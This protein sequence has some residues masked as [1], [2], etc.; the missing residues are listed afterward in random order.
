MIVTNCRDASCSVVRFSGCGREDCLRSLDH[1]ADWL[2]L[3]LQPLPMSR[4]PSSVSQL[5]PEVQSHQSQELSEP[6]MPRPLGDVR[7]GA[8]D[9]V[10]WLFSRRGQPPTGFH[11]RA[12]KRL[13]HTLSNRCQSF[14]TTFRNSRSDATGVKERG[15]RQASAPHSSKKL[16]VAKRC[17]LR[18]APW[19][20]PPINA[21]VEKRCGALEAG[22]LPHRCVVGTK[23]PR[24]NPRKAGTM[25]QH[26]GVSLARFLTA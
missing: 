23:R 7:E 18:G 14:N 15:D 26:L 16:P 8:L 10:I 11:P 9:R 17:V 3:L 20:V 25:P 6:H 5:Y 2:N 19:S 13:R 21:D 12:N 1:M 24:C 4:N 22:T